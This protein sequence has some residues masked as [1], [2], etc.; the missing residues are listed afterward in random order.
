MT[1]TT[2]MIN[3]EFWIL[4]GFSGVLFLLIVGLMVAFVIRYHRSRHPVPAD[5]SGNFWLELTWVAV[6]TLLVLGLFYIGLTGYLFERRAPEDS[7]PVKVLAF[8][9]GWTFTYENGRETDE[10]YV[11]VGR[12]VRLLLT[13]KDV[14]HSFFV[15]AFRIKQDA[16][17]GLTTTMWFQAET[18]GEFDV[19]CA[20]YCGVGHSAMLSKVVAMPPEEFS[21]WYKGSEEQEETAERTGTAGTVATAPAAPSRPPQAAAP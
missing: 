1:R 15:P 11:P 14:I 7:M 6:P 16:V 21:T 20:E 2:A 19:L 3:R 5:I 17:P 13:S 10:L 18:P 8:Q 4:F 12:P 9:Y